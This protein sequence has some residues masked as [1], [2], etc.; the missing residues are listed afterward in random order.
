VLPE[1]NSKQGSSKGLLD[2]RIMAH[3][4]IVVKDI[5]KASEAYSELLGMEVPKWNIASSHESKPTKYH[6]KLTDG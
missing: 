6:S 5:E 4:A 2:N 3:V 1:M